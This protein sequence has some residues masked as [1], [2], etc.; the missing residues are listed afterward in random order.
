MFRFQH[1]DGTRTELAVYDPAVAAWAAAAEA[2]A[3]TRTCYGL[4]LCLRVLALASRLAFTGRVLPVSEGPAPGAAARRRARGGGGPEP[5]AR[6]MRAAAHAALD[7]CGGF[8]EA[9]LRALLA[10][11]TP[12][13][14]G[15][16]R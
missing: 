11:A 9:S 4:S 14:Q 7:R 2:V 15:L 6:L 5:D 8:D 13:M 10:A 3:S 16:G 12:Q 1:A